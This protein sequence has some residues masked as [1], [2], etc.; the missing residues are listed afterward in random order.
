MPNQIYPSD[1][2]DSQWDL[3]KEL[4]PPAKHGGRPRNLDVRQVVNAI[5]YLL[6]TGIQWRYL[7]A[8]V[9]EMAKRLPLL[10]TV[11]AGWDME[12]RS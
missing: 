4:I 2:T 3:I 11:A 8:R 9:S 12:T 7:A 6:V 1:L 5:L 10:P